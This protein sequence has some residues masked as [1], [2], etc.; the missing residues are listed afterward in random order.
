[1]GLDIQLQDELGRR[2]EGVADTNNRLAGV[3]S[4]YENS[5][6]YPMPAGIDRYGDTVFNRLQIPRFLSEWSDVVSKAQT[7]EDRD[8]ASEIARLAR[9]CS[10][11]IH[12]PEVYW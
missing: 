9:R 4:A 10:D 5:A 12:L 3:R 8:L 2:I 7:P 11:E 1:V 6:A